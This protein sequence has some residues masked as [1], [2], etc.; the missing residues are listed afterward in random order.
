MCTC[1]CTDVSTSQEVLHVPQASLPP[2]C[3]AKY[4]GMWQKKSTFLDSLSLYP[5]P[6]QGVLYLDWKR[7]WRWKS[8][9]LWVFKKQR[10]LTST[11]CVR[12]RPCFSRV[13]AANTGSLLLSSSGCRTFTRIHIGLGSW[14]HFCVCVQW[15]QLE[16][17]ELTRARRV[18]VS[19]SDNDGGV[20]RYHTHLNNWVYSGRTA[21]KEEPTAVCFGF[22]NVRALLPA[23]SQPSQLQFGLPVKFWAIFQ[24]YRQLLDYVAKNGS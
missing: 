16:S 10:N 7:L 17:L 18:W 6:W 22:M 19:V 2:V 14:K 4:C 12:F 20:G 24:K 3:L 9:L 1:Y 11:T 21:G 5:K 15:G 8:L 13:M 23:L